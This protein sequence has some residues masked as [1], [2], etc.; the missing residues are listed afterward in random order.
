MS[1]L[2]LFDMFTLNTVYGIEP[3]EILQ[4]VHDLEAGDGNT[5]TKIATPFKHPP[6]KGL[7]HKHYFAAR[8]LAHNIQ[9]GLG[10][11]GLREIV[12]SSLL[13]H[14]GETASAET[15]EQML[16]RVT[17]EPIEKRY[18]DRA[19]TGEW[20]IFARRGEA[21]YYLCV[22]THNHGDDEIHKRI[23]DVASMDFPDVAL[24]MAD[25]H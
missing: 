23:M 1:R 9:L 22:S 18:A 16:L 2:F 7:W 3:M 15:I 20:V 17:T 25:N 4:S 19:M 12:E 21:N 6:L 11:N 5:G 24:W 13:P 10:K 8:F 14:L